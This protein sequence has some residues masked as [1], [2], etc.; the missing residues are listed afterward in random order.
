MALKT[1]K[2]AKTYQKP[3]PDHPWRQYPNKIKVEVEVELEIISVK[4]YLTSLVN[5]WDKVEVSTKIPGLGFRTYSLS[6]LSQK[7]VAAYIAGKLKQH[8]V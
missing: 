7:K 8:Y 4:E 3:K 2:K 6:Q 5:N 1:S